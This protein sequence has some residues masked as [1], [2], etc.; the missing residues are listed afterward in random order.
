MG[1]AGRGSQR[2]GNGLELLE[3]AHQPRDEGLGDV[4]QGTVARDQD[5]DLQRVQ[6]RDVERPPRDVATAGALR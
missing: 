3:L 4:R 2:R 1:V 5:A 6:L